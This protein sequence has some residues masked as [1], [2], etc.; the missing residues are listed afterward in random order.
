MQPRQEAIEGDEAGAALED[1]IKT[2]LHLGLAAARGLLFVGDEV[3]VEPPDQGA[4]PLLGHASV[5]GECVELVDETLGMHPAQGMAPDIELP[6]VVTDD[7]SIVQKTMRLDGAEQ[8][9]LGGDAHRIGC[10]GKRG[11]AEPLKMRHPGLGIGKVPLRLGGEMVDDGSRQGTLAHIGE[12]LLVENVVA[13]A[14]A[15]EFEKVEP[16][17]GAGGAEP[18]EVVVPDLGA[19]GIGAPVAGARVID[20]NEAGRLQSSPQDITSLGEKNLLLIDQQA[21]DL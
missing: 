10:D 5:L 3:A 15:Q 19:D 16:A 9:S 18:G 6:G 17:F 7:D 13:V 12:S 21:H 11:D 2:D 4:N 20:S 8:G 1:A 14:G